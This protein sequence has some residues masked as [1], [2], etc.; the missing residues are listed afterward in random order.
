[1]LAWQ[2]CEVVLDTIKHA[3]YVG[4]ALGVMNRLAAP[5]GPSPCESSHPEEASYDT[6]MREPCDNQP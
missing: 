3:A 1:M 2:P 5:F 6:L 4:L